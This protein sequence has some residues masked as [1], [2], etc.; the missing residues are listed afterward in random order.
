MSFLEGLALTLFVPAFKI[1]RPEHSS[2][3]TLYAVIRTV[4]NLIKDRANVVVRP[5]FS[6]QSLMKPWKDAHQ[7]RF[8]VVATPRLYAN[9]K[10][11]VF[12]LKHTEDPFSMKISRDVLLQEV[13][14]G[15]RPYC[16]PEDMNAEDPLFILYTS[17]IFTASHQRPL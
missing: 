2:Q 11:H 14:T 10:E 15:E 13:M 16:P 3:Q 6:N 12:V 5:S 8:A 4:N 17:G 7:L 1:L 9:A